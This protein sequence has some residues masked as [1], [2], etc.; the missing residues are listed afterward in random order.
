MRE[1]TYNCKHVKDCV[2]RRP[3]AFKNITTCDYTL[4]SEDGKS[5]GCPAD[6]CDKYIRRDS[7]EGKKILKKIRKDYYLDFSRHSIHS[8]FPY[9]CNQTSYTS[10]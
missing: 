5:R 1:K 6:K 9:I 4:M 8:M 10:I 7:Y 2:Y 3:T